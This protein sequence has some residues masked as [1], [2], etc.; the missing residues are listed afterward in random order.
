MTW[1]QKP[2]KRSDSHLFID[3]NNMIMVLD[4]GLRNNTRQRSV[5]YDA[6]LSHGWSWEY[7]TH[8]ILAM[9]AVIQKRYHVDVDRCLLISKIN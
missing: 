8:F 5:V 3:N 2:E 4:V 1:F 9:A 6:G 7:S